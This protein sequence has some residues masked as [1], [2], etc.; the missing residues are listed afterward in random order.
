MAKILKDEK[1]LTFFD[2][3]SPHVAVN[4]LITNAITTSRN[5]TPTSRGCKIVCK[6]GLF[7]DLG[8]AGY[9]TYRDPPH[10]RKQALTLNL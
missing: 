5:F 8:Q 2:N 10:P 1:I 6:R 4:S 3:V 7:I 9:L